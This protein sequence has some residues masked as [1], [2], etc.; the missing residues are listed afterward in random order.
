MRRFFIVAIA[1]T[2]WVSQLAAI[3][4]S[5]TVVYI[6]GTKYYVHVVKAGDTLYSL[7]KAYDVSEKDII[8]NNAGLDAATLRIDQ[9][10]KIPV[11]EQ[12]QQQRKMTRKDKKRFKRH[13]VKSG[14][15]LYSIARKYEISVATIMEDNPGIDPTALSV[16]Y[17]LL[18]RKSDIGDTPAHTVEREWH[19]YKETLNTLTPTDSASYHIVQPGETIYSLSRR[20]GMTEEEF[21][22]LNDLS[23][24]LKAGAIVRV[25]RNEDTAGIPEIAP[26]DSLQTESTD[27]PENEVMQPAAF[28][29]LNPYERL[30]IALMLPVDV[31]NKVNDNYI[32][33][34]KG[35]LLALE[36]LKN[37]DRLNADLTVFNTAH[38]PQTMRT[39]I[40]CDARLRQADIIVGPVYEE[41][42]RTVLEYAQLSNT[43]V[44]SPLSTMTETRSPVL[45]QMQAANA[46]K[47]DKFAGMFDGSREIALIYAASNDHEFASEIKPLLDSS[48][49][50]SYNFTF[51]RKP[52]IYRRNA[53]GSNGAQVETNSLVRGQSDKIFIIMADKETD[54]DRILTTLS[55]AKSSITD[56][57]YTIGSYVVLGNRKWTRLHNLDS[58]IF[59]KNDV[60]FA[61][62]YHAKRSDEAIRVFDGAYIKEFGTLPS[63]FSYRG[64]DAAMLFCRAMYDGMESLASG[65]ESTPLTTSYKFAYENGMYVNTD[66]TEE[67]YNSNFTIT[68]E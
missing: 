28:R 42:I 49:Y 32:D 11:I 9:T 59:F 61:T 19:D 7:A 4:R 17:E 15:T 1:L 46:H 56:R 13:N 33:F 36:Q 66:W 47:Y 35:F 27:L 50:E 52:F 12:Q 68:T 44:V 65:E 43:P 45:F 31:K 23:D 20:F 2:M 40:D 26:V 39:L 34:Y 6:N 10:I 8:D 64:Y 3:E 41:E 53:D 24:G 25:T 38:D 60:V 57:G 5:T 54:I 16:D 18:I 30:H 62:P 21:S 58:R 37:E 63:M 67:R 22:Q 51:N 14:E 55:S 29:R 48:R